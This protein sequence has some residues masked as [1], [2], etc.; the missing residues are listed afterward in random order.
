MKSVDTMPSLIIIA[1]P[2]HAKPC[3]L[4]EN[5][6]AINAYITTFWHSRPM[7]SK[8]RAHS[9]MLYR[10]IIVLTVS[11]IWPTI[12]KPTT[13]SIER[14]IPS[15]WSLIKYPAMKHRTILG[16]ASKAYKP[17][18]LTLSMLKTY[19]PNKTELSLTSKISFWTG[20]GVYS[21]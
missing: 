5:Q 7:P 17:L 13:M 20:A 18:N 10:P 12:M 6:S 15:I 1:S 21:Q 8:I 16:N 11:R 14:W 19:K 3:S 2:A 9:A 4:P